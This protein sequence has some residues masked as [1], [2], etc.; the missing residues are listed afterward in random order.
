MNGGIFGKRINQR[1]LLISQTFLIFLF[2]FQRF[3]YAE[4]TIT[5]YDLINL[6]NGLRTGGG[7]SALTVDANLMACAQYTAETMAAANMSGHIGG[8]ANRA[9]AFGYNNGGT[10]WATENYMAGASLTLDQI[11]IAW[12]DYDHMRPM[13]DS[14]YCSIGAGVAEINGKTYYVVQAAY[15]ATGSSC[16]YSGSSNTSNSANSGSTSGNIAASTIDVSQIIKNV[17]V[18]TP[19][20]D[21]KIFHTVQ[22]GQTLWSIAIAYN[23]TIDAITAWNAAISDITELSLGETLRIPSESDMAS[24]PTPESANLPTADALGEYHH[25]V[26]AGETLWSIAEKWHTTVAELQRWNGLTEDMAIGLDWNLLIPITPTMTL[27]PTET[28]LPTETATATSTPTVTAASIRSSTPGIVVT[29]ERPE[30][31]SSLSAKVWIIISI[32]IIG[33]IGAALLIIDSMSSHKTKR[34]KQRK[35]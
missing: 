27:P 5:A 7:L 6:V 9:S 25:K 34:K 15:P 28:P 8:V 22:E 31:R 30:D 12:S 26:Q 2:F 29:L 3:A 11:Q 24:T 14:N 21:G 35:P 23:T 17:T 1:G 13:T 20:I 18:S 33:V 4:N 16:A 32:S 10:C 19:D